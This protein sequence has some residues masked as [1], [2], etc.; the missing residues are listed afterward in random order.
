MKFVLTLFFPVLVM[1]FFCDTKAL[2]QSQLVE[3]Q[4]Y[5]NTLYNGQ[6]INATANNALVVVQESQGLVN[7]RIDLNSFQ[8][9]ID[10]LDQ[11]MQ[12]LRNRY[13]WYSGTLP[14][15]QLVSLNPESSLEFQSSGTFGFADKSSKEMSVPMAAMRLAPGQGFYEGRDVWGQLRLAFTIS[16]DPDDFGLQLKDSALQEPLLI[17]VKSGRINPF[18]MGQRDITK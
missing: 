6:S 9:G 8:S 12:T 17:S 5:L 4:V 18:V 11:W 2:A 13:F 16:V 1:L 10:S 3:S 15:E 7:I 14:A